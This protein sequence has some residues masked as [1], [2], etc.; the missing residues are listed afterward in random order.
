MNIDGS[1]SIPCRITDHIYLATGGHPRTRFDYVLHIS[2]ESPIDKYY[3]EMHQQ[4]LEGNYIL[5][6]GRRA[7][8]IVIYYYLR[9]IYN[10]Q[11]MWR[12][13]RRNVLRQIIGF[14]ARRFPYV[15][16]TQKDILQLEKLESDLK[17][18]NHV[19]FN[20]FYAT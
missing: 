10:I 15:Q 5:L 14:V 1:K 16:F 9:R 7:I 8:Y 4:I 2:H 19:Q 11:P 3:K 12:S 17:N 18:E 13:R 6:Y 20:G